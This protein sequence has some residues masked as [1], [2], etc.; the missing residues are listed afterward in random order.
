MNM[1]IVDRRIVI[2]CA[3]EGDTTLIDASRLPSDVAND[4]LRAAA[5]KLR[6]VGYRVLDQRQ[7]T[8]PCG[9][10]LAGPRSKLCEECRRKALAHQHQIN[11]RLLRR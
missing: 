11:S 2:D 8:C 1:V 4:I 9:K 3:L 6:K 5:D 7:H 10:P